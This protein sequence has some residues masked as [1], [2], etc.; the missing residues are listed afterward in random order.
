MKH[1]LICALQEVAYRLRERLTPLKDL[2][3]SRLMTNRQGNTECTR[4]KKLIKDKEKWELARVKEA[5][6]VNRQNKKEFMELQKAI[7]EDAVEAERSRAR[8][9]VLDKSIRDMQAATEQVE[10][11]IKEKEKELARLQRA[12]EESTFGGPTDE[13]HDDYL[14]AAEPEADSPEEVIKAH[15]STS[16][17]KSPELAGL[18]RSKRRSR[19]MTDDDNAILRRVGAIS[20]TVTALADEFKRFVGTMQNRHDVRYLHFMP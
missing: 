15:K 7:V 10:A 13:G 18:G 6:K 12:D 20:T 17:A 3:Q 2:P 5:N 19:I 1:T 9:K 11:E 8:Q 4:L 16:R 14:G